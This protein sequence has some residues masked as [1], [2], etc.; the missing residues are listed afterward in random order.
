MESLPPDV[1][2]QLLAASLAI[3]IALL[4]WIG[5]RVHKKLDELS[6]ALIAMNSTLTGI[7]RDLRSELTSLDRR[8]AHV[9]GKIGK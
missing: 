4:A 5:A 9:E 1:L 8:I 2:T 7:E 6:G 3:L